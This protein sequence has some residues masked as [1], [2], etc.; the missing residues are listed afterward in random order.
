MQRKLHMPRLAIPRGICD[1]YPMH[2]RN[3]ASPTGRSS[4]AAPR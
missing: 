3:P 1:K 2:Q 4:T